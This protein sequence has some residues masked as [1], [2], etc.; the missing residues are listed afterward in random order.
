[1]K[2]HLSKELIHPNSQQI[3]SMKKVSVIIFDRGSENLL[4]TL[5]SFYI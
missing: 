4:S 2:T 5:K 3:G 1:M